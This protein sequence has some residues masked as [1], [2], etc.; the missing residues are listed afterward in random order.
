M[1]NQTLIRYSAI[2]I[3]VIRTSYHKLKNLMRLLKIKGSFMITLQNLDITST[4]A[5][6]LKLLIIQQLKT[7]LALCNYLIKHLMGNN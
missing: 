5:C 1:K 6:S 3:L 2:S 7:R 4:T